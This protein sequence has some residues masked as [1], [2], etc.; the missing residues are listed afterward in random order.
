MSTRRTTLG[1]LILVAAIAS[2]QAM[3]QSAWDG[4]SFNITAGSFF[5]SSDT[6]LRIDGEEFGT[7]IDV[8]NVLGLEEDESLSRFS[9]DWRFAHRHSL[10]FGYYGL[11]RTASKHLTEEIIVDDDVYPV[12]A[13]V[14]AELKLSFYEFSYT[15][16]LMQRE[17]S[18][19]GITGVI[20]SVAVSARLDAESQGGGSLELSNR[21]TTDLPVV[22]IGVSY[23]HM[24]GKS[25]VFTGDAT[26]LPE[27][28]YDNYT[29]SSLNLN[30]GLEYEFLDHYGIGV[31]YDSFGIEFEA[32]GDRAVGKFEYDIEGPQ[33]YFK[34]FW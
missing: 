22:L 16:W 3:A 31:A 13:L 11:K 12:D 32:D 26:F 18:G 17:R 23:R 1:L 30:V 4:R 20:V 15:Y 25:F 8:E 5:Q 29:G 10:S 27:I 9:A 7:E 24:L 33:A 34:F 2:S 21:A 28:T 6:T 14:E 19:L